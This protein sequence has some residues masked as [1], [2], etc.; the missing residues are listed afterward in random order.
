MFIFLKIPQK[1]QVLCLMDQ[2][3]PFNSF[4]LRHKIKLDMTI[5]NKVF[6]DLCASPR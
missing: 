2:V 3:I 5:S 6:I 1:N 4:L